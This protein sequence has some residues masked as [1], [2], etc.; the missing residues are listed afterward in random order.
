MNHKSIDYKIITIA[1][2]VI[3]IIFL[4]KCQSGATQ[5]AYI[6]KNN[7]AVSQDSVTHYKTKQ[8]TLVYE[9]G[10]LIS[11]S[12]SLSELN[13][14]LQQEVKQLKKDIDAEPTIIIKEE[15]VIIH[16][17]VLVENVTTRWLNDSTFNVVFSH[18]TIYD[19]IG[20]SRS[21]AGSLVSEI[22]KLDSNKYS[23]NVT[24][25]MLTEDEMVMHSTLAIGET[26]DKKLKVYVTSKY[27][28]FNAKSIDAII[29]DPN[30]HP[31]LRKL[32]NNK[33]FTVGPYIGIGIGQN[34]TFTPSFGI[35]L[36]YSLFKF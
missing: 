23:V 5:E 22:R 8:G 7:L 11:T 18:D 24:E 21:I 28:N 34:F 3:V 29:L 9:K 31:E 14:S 4:Q 35:G 30:I 17:T 16:D 26:E 33:K 15:I 20:N 13:Y 36:Q 32:S 6:L 27:P 12:K 19:T 10:V 25:F 1:I 2:L